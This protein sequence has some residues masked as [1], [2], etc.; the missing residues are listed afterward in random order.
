MDAS[1][2]AKLLKGCRIG[3]ALTLSGWCVSAIAASGGDIGCSSSDRSLKSLTVSVDNLAVRPIDHLPTGQKSTSIAT[4]A[5]DAV[6]KAA[7][8]VLK[9]APNISAMLNSVFDAE[10]ESTLAQSETETR[11]DEGPTA[12]PVRKESEIGEVQLPMNAI[13]PSD[14]VARFQRQMYRKDI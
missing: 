5:T 9:L 14:D 4:E 7:G 3:I 2:R 1:I 10:D 12:G 11:N 8:P 6:S 13:V